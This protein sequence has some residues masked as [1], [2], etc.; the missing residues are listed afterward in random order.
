MRAMQTLSIRC[1]VHGVV[2]EDKGVVSLKTSY[3]SPV[4]IRIIVFRMVEEDSSLKRWDLNKALKDVRV[5][6]KEGKVLMEK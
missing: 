4:K 6:P 5:F 1:M 2:V 3:H